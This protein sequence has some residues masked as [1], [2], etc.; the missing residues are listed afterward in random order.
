MKNN[1]SN[2]GGQLIGTARTAQ[3][4]YVTRGVLPDRMDTDE[5]FRKN[6]DERTKQAKIVALIA[7]LLSAILAFTSAAVS[8]AGMLAQA[9]VNNAVSLNT[10]LSTLVPACAYGLV[11]WV[12]AGYF[13]S[14]MQ[15]LTVW[16]IRLACIVTCL[17]FTI[18]V[19]SGST[20]L[21][22]IGLTNAT[23]RVSY[24]EEQNRIQKAYADNLGGVIAQV[25]AALPAMVGLENDACEAAQA[26]RASGAISGTGRGH[27]P[28]VAA[29]MSTCNSVR[30]M[31]ADLEGKVATA[32]R[33]IES[34]SSLLEE[35]GYIIIDRTI[36]IDEREVS[37]QKASLKL[38][39]TARRYRNK[40]L[41]YGVKGALKVI[42][43]VVTAPP[44]GIARGARDAINAQREKLQAISVALQSIVSSQ[45]EVGSYQS[46]I[47]PTL[48]E[49]ARASAHRLIAHAVVAV[50]LDLFVPLTMLI[51][52]FLSVEPPRRRQ[53]LDSR[54]NQVPLSPAIALKAV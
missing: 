49:L 30:G 8:Y 47:R 36:P 4:T 32:N 38:E 17:M 23:I 7:I 51:T 25:N 13:F 42:E 41:G 28:T 9:E 19:L 52:Y 53:H 18:S 21:N 14:T 24:L 46:A 5:A 35:T 54:L 29:L 16:K 2:T 48:E 27:G 34:I 39:S 26:E 11:N 3:V 43:N 31:R 15:V 10:A 20:T 44:A 6:K 1:E 50:S 22:F 37:F 40:G 12:L 45:N 33:E